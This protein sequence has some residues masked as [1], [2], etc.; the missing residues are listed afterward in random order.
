MLA[1]QHDQIA[2]ELVLNCVNSADLLLPEH[3][4]HHLH[5]AAAAELVLNCVNSADLLLP[6]HSCHCALLLLSLS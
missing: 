1:Q 4:C 6:E 5:I 2:A 3:S